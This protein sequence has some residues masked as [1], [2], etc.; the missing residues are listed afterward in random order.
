MDRTAT[1]E[2]RPSDQG[3]GTPSW[4]TLGR[5][6][7]HVHRTPDERFAGL[8]DFAFEPRYLEVDG[9]RM[10]YVDHGVGRTVL[11]LHG[12]PTWSF[13]YRKLIPILADGG[14]RAVTPDLFGFGRSDKPTDPAFY[15][16]D[17]H[18]ASL[19][20]FVNRLDLSR[21]TLVVHDWGGPIGLHVAVEHPDRFARLVVLNTGLYSPSERWPTPAF[22]EWRTF[23]ERTGLELPVG[24]VVRAGCLHQPP[25]EVI[26]AYDAPF[27]TPESKTGAS[28]FPLMVPLSAT[29]PGAAE[30]HAV[31][32]ALRSW[33]KPALVLFGD[34]DPVF[35]PGAASAM[36]RLI[37]T[38]RKPEIIEGAAHFVQE[39][40]GEQIAERILEFVR[41]T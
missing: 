33:N 26:A 4:D 7:L 36:A 12:E 22:V 19:T 35:P 38:V 20:E 31:R 14:L 21:I 2:W 30:M 6:D 10:H 28:M 18:V 13:L 39:D 34:S 29:D 23:A 8:P 3:L 41:R 15:S 32:D 40:R 24:L 27:D 25:P 5:V 37:P 9:L 11:L 16:Y 1:F 17:R